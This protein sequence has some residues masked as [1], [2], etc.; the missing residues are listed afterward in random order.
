MFDGRS[1]L[2][3]LDIEDA[4]V[5]VSFP[6]AVPRR[7]LT[8]Q[9]ECADEVRS[10]QILVLFDEGCLSLGD[11]EQRLVGDRGVGLLQ[12]LLS[13]LEVSGSDVG[14]GDGRRGLV[15]GLV[16]RSFLPEPFDIKDYARTAEGLASAGAQLRAATAEVHKLVVSEDVGVVVERT[17][18]AARSLANHI[19]L[20]GVLLIVVFFVAAFVY[21]LVS[22]RLVKKRGQ[23]AALDDSNPRQ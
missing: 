2:F 22:T 9:L 11:E 23:E 14:K 7:P 21:R 12:F 18:A 10:R 13:L 19:A 3:G 6:V 8:V 15:V 1:I 5:E 16:R 17:D 4:E 20:L